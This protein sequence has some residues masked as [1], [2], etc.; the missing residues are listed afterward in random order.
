MLHI[1]LYQPEIPPNT[2]S[3]ARQCVGMNACLHII[4]PIAFD[5]GENAVKRAGLDYWDRLNLTIHANPDKF[6]TWLG[7]R[8]PWLVTKHGALR[9]DKPDFRDMDI[10]IFGSE[11]SG[12]PQDWLERWTYRAIHIPMPGKVRNYNLSNTVSVILAQACL[13]AG[14]F[15]NL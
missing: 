11:I 8:E 13:S 9:F 15:D 2:G 7:D 5:I 4:G 14:L 10:I 12:L 6:L 1:V 3:I